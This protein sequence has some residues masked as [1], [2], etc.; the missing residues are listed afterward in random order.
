MR[1]GKNKNNY[2]NQF[3]CVF[4]ILK[5]VQQYQMKKNRIFKTQLLTVHSWLHN[6]LLLYSISTFVFFMNIRK[7]ILFVN[8]Y[9]T[10]L[11]PF[12]IFLILSA[13]IIKDICAS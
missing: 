2:N 7:S 11:F 1:F 3:S 10:I 9:N 6:W 8:A 5:T 13:K 4:N 12:E